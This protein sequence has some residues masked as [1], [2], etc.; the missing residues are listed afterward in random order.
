ME[1]APYQ[2]CVKARD[3]AWI[4]LCGRERFAAC[5]RGRPAAKTDAMIIHSVFFWLKPELTDAQRAEFVA[6]AESLHGIAS[7]QSL[8][9]GRPAPIVPRPVVDGSYTYALSITFKDV[10]GHDA[11]QVD[12]AHRA[13][14]DKFKP[15]WNKVQIYDAAN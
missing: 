4:N 13:F 10:A 8:F 1:I 11:Y 7:V 2:R 9:L 6:G 12:P 5:Q 14:V 3:D 15:F